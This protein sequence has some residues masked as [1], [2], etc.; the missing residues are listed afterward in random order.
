MCERGKVKCLEALNLVKF[1]GGDEP[2]GTPIYYPS[3]TQPL[4]NVK[5]KAIRHGGAIPFCKQKK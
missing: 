4:I 5:E 1:V 3:G 2:P